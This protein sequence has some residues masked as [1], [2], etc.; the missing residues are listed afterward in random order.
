MGGLGYSGMLP[1]LVM[2]APPA[3]APAREEALAPNAA[4]RRR[5]LVVDDN[6]DATDSMAMLLSVW[7]HDTRIANDGPSAL[8]LAA[9]F[10][11]EVVIL[12]IGLPGMDGYEVARRMHEMPGLRGTVLVAMT[13]YGQEEDRMRS[14]AA[15]FARHVVKPA[16]PGALRAMLESLPE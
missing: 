13:G 12:D 6:R 7:G 11:P 8:G 3:G 10:Q 4:V 15:G 5:V 2:A 16:D 1:C 9:E 14:K